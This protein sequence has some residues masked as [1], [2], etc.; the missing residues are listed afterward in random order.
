METVDVFEVRRKKI[1]DL[2]YEFLE[3]LKEGQS[4]GISIENDVIRKVEESI[5]DFEKNYEELNVALIGAFSEGKTTLAAAWIGKF[6]KNSMKVSISESSDRVEVYY[7][8]D[9]DT[10]NKIKLVDT[11][12]LFGSGSTDEGIKYREITEKY[13]SEAH[14]I[15]YVM[16]PINPIKESHREE[17]VWLFKTLG[18]L[19]RTIFVLGKFDNVADL[20]SKEE[21]SKTYT[22][23]RQI[24]VE[25]LKDFGIIDS[26]DE[27]IDIVA[28]SANPFGEGMDYW[29]KNKKEYE[30]LSRIKTLREA[31]TRKIA[32]LGSKE[33]IL[34]ETQKSI[35]K[36]ISVRNS[37]EVSDKLNKYTRLIEDK[38]ENLSEAIEDLSQN[39]EEIL[40]S[41]EQLVS[42]LNNVRK[43]LVA[44]IRTAVPET[45]P[46][47][48]ASRLGNEGEIFKTDIENEMRSYVESV[49]NSLDNTINTYVKA[50][51]ITDKMFSDALKKGAGA[52][53]L[54]KNG[55]VINN[56]TVLAFRDVV[57]KGF[58]FNP[59]GA[60]KLATGI[61]NAIP[62][63]GVA[64]TALTYLSDLKKEKEFE[65]DKDRLA[66]QINEIITS[67]LDTVSD[68]DKFIEN[69]FQSYLETEKL[70]AE[71]QHNLKI[72]EE[73]KD[74][75]ENWQEHG[76]KLRDKFTNLIKD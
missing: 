5:G 32:N 18:L 75:L 10:D 34:L 69:Y 66:N 57:A 76:K 54:I 42:Y 12:G 14:L 55:N 43:S 3:Y 46:E 67:L 6:D 35:I 13:V 29:F 30:E 51:S 37:A 1:N 39:R 16:D 15:L 26:D 47:I 68:T 60:T 72:L 45:L 56:N 62:V 36:D 49:N 27:K 65:E 40:N 48:I 24:V 38:R 61:N 20:E 17:V 59:W 8:T 2:L 19:P 23:K 52:L 11:P 64:I 9:I 71:E 31:T 50:T 74:N 41:Q 58:K 4:N 28:V 53:T 44:D 7:D 21:Y 22:K 63:I 73:I 70:L 33:K 25:R